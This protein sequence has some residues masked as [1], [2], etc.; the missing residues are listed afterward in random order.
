MKYNTLKA[1]DQVI[2]DLWEIADILH[3]PTREA[4]DKARMAAQEAW[5]VVKREQE[6]N[7]YTVESGYDRN[8][9]SLREILK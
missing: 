1:L 4:V 8:N 5:N 3:G 9:N 6:A 7:G 2:S